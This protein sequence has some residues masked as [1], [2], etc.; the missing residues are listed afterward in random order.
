MFANQLGNRTS[1]IR[2]APLLLTRK[3]ILLCANDVDEWYDRRV[4]VAANG[5]KTAACG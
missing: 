1:D 4:G 5:G 3:G 2:P